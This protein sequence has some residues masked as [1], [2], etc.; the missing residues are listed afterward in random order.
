MFDLNEIYEEFMTDYTAKKGHSPSETVVKCCKVI[1]SVGEEFY[2]TGKRDGENGKKLS[3]DA[4]TKWASSKFTVDSSLNRETTKMLR[5][6]YL[7]G[8][9]DG[10]GA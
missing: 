7:E 3:D 2:N 4:L 8:W 10:G 1:I 6:C 5:R 9:K